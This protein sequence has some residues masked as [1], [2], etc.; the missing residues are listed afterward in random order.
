M[1]KGQR[2]YKQFFTDPKIIA[3]FEEHIRA[4]LNHKNV[5]TGIAYKD[6]P[7]ILAWENCNVCGS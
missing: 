2:D 7:T 3:E 4:V 6:D 1:W 5:L